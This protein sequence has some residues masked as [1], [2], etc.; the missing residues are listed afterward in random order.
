MRYNF[1][2]LL[3]V[4]LIAIGPVFLPL[5]MILFGYTL[6]GYGGWN[7]VPVFIRDTPVI[8]FLFWHLR[9]LLASVYVVAWIIWV[10]T[11][12]LG[13]G[14]NDANDRRDDSF[15]KS[16]NSIDPMVVKVLVLGLI[17]TAVIGWVV[18][19]I[20]QYGMTQF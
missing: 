12:V 14:Y 10:A 11:T 1:R 16:N 18:Y 2:R 5:V 17:C 15:P 8:G 6:G 13:G 19:S 7:S 20:M 4:V 3:L 9:T